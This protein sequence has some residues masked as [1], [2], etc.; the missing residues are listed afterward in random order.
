MN[1]RPIEVGLSVN[2]EVSL[3]N[4]ICVSVVTIRVQKIIMQEPV[5]IDEVVPYAKSLILL[6]YTGFSSHRM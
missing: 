1:V 5:R 3:W 4:D 6:G 2:V